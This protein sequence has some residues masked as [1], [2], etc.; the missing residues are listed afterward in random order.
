MNG[1]VVGVDGSPGAAGALRFAAELARARGS[2]LH[3]VCAW[4]MPAMAF[5]GGVYV[6][7]DDLPTALEEGAR[8]V[9]ADA[10]HGL[11]VPVEQHALQGHASEVLLKAAEGADMLVVGSRGLGG[12]ARLLLGSVSHGVVHH[13][14]CP[15]VVVPGYS[16]QR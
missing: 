7:D 6:G 8:R 14:P 15:V 5:A 16:D 12:F 11:D 13:A 1:I 9:L 2:E 10:V 3:A 4:Q